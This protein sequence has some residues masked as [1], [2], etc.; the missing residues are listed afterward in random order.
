MDHQIQIHLTD[1][2]IKNEKGEE[3]DI[4][5]D[6]KVLIVRRSVWENWEKVEKE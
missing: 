2:A 3:K 1:I 4:L 5:G 6:E